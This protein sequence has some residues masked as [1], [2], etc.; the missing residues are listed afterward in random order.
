[1]KHIA[2]FIVMIAILM[3]IGF[4]IVSLLNYRLKKRIIESGPIDENSLKFLNKL[5]GFGP[6]VL[7]WGI[8][9]LF[10]G[11][12]LVL[13]EFI[14]YK[15]EESSLPYGIEAIFIAIGF[16]VYYFLVVRKDKS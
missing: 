5:S 4:V 11:I 9:L 10:G 8:I 7:K 14:P 1:M 3:I 15:A 16:L 2:P 6:E 13:L 12:G